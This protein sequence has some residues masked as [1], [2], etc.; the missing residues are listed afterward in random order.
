HTN[1]AKA[2]LNMLTHSTAGDLARDHIF[3]NSVDPGWIS[4]Q[5][6]LPDVALTGEQASQIPLDEVDAAARICDPIFAGIV[7]GQ[8]AF[9]KL[10]KD[11]HE[12]PW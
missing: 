4:Q 8:P 9:G 11:Y 2:A 10:F 12:A 6:P 1:M 3:L 5:G 7:T